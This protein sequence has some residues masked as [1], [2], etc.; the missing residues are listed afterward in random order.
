MWM[1][2][3]V[4]DCILTEEM[5]QVLRCVVSFLYISDVTGL[6]VLDGVGLVYETE[7]EG[8]ILEKVTN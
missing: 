4:A 6:R 3:I 8:S 2:V 5:I 1:L 7:L